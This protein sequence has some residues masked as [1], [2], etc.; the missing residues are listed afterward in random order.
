[1]KILVA[2]DSFK[3]SLESGEAGQA[4]ARGIRNTVADAEITIMEVGDGGEG[5]MKTIT[6][7]LN[8]RIIKCSTLDPLGRSIMAEYGII[9]IDD[10][11]TAV[12]DVSAASGLGLLA[13]D[14]RKVISTSSYGTGIL[15]SNAL[16]RGIRRFIIGLGGSA[17]CDGG[18]GMLAALGYKIIAENGEE[19]N[20]PVGKDLVRIKQIKSND[21]NALH[22]SRFMI[23]SDVDNPLCGKNGAVPV[24]APQKGASPEDILALDTGMVNYAKILSAIKNIDV[25]NMK[26]GGAAGGIGAALLTATKGEIKSG[27]EGVLDILKFDEKVIDCDLV[28]T[29]EGKID[30]QTLHGKLPYTVCCR[31]SKRGI[32]TVAVAGTVEHAP[33]LLKARFAGVFSI[34]QGNITL[35]ESMKPKVAKRNL[36]ECSASIIKLFASS[37]KMHDKFH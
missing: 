24:F 27:A 2:C 31:A 25:A 26:G 19:I 30:R 35:Q 32:P 14:D 11:E 33:E 28:I 12:I 13:E 16:K 10:A 5:T 9:K 3:G 29:G 18:A 1:M 36:E 21:F 22:E 23:F 17:T 20:M 8:G 34:Q 15:I 37:T 4:I 7:A 6:R